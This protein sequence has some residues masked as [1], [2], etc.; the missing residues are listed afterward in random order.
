M[1]RGRLQ[2]CSSVITRQVKSSQVK[3]SQVKSVGVDGDKDGDEVH[4]I[5]L[6]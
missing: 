5:E 2:K 4:L 6:I 1:D 3:S